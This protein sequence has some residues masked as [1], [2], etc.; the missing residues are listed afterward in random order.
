[1]SYAILFLLLSGGIGFVFIPPSLMYGSSNPFVQVATMT[2][3]EE[4]TGTETGTIHVGHVEVGSEFWTVYAA[5]QHGVIQIVEE[6]NL[7]YLHV[8][9]KIT[10]AVLTPGN[11]KISLVGTVE[12]PTGSRTHTAIFGPSEGLR[13]SGIYT[14][15]VSLLA[16][17]TVLSTTQATFSL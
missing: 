2:L 8:A 17:K 15:T 14:A 16:G 11:E 5:Q 13:L 1:M 7:S 9:L 6:L 3:L 4:T 10:V 12:G